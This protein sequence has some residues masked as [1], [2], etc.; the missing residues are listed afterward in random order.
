[1]TRV[2]LVITGCLL[3]VLAGSGLLA[4]AHTVRGAALTAPT[5]KNTLSIGWSIETKTLDPAGT[6]RL[7]AHV[8]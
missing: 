7:R 8:P 2:R 5:S 3:A 4:G 6:P 1:M